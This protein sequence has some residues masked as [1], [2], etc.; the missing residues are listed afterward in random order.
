MIFVKTTLTHFSTSNHRNAN[1]LLWSLEEA[2]NLLRKVLTVCNSVDN[3]MIYENS[4]VSYKLCL[5]THGV[6][7]ATTPPSIMQLVSSFV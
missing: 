7:S 5:N 4:F 3:Y 6:E 1:M 2:S